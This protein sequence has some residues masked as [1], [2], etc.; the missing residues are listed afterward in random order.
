[1]LTNYVPFNEQEERDKEVMLQWISTGEDLFTRE[2]PFA[3]FS[4]SAWIVDPTHTKVLMAFHNIYQSYSWLGGHNDGDRDF[5][6]V[7]TKEIQEESSLKH[8]HLVS[9]EIFSIEILTVNGHEKHG[10]YV[11]SHL[12][13]NLTYL[14]EADMH[15]DLHIKPDENSA[16]AWF[17]KQEAL[18]RCTEDWMRDRVYVKLNQKLE[19][20]DRR[21]CN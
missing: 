10:V 13:L 15:D 11:P 5:I 19:Q 2:N 9:D 18:D 17:E 8:F 20:W 21:S 7:A 16:I 4:A 6:H 14:F 1:M 12:H 3:H